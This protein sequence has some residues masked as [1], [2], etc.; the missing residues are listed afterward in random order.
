LM[1]DGKAPPTTFKDLKEEYMYKREEV[2]D[3]HR[4]NVERNRKTRIDTI[5]PIEKKWKEHAEHPR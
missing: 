1:Q 5:R 4:H 2:M 3:R